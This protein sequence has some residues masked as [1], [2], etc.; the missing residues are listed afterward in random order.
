M[1]QTETLKRTDR[2]EPFPEPEGEF[3]ALISAGRD[4]MQVLTRVADHCGTEMSDGAVC[5]RPADEC[6]YHDQD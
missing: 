2:N 5:T 1:L 4:T 3:L 6:S